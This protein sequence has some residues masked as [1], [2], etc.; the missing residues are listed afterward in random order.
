MVGLVFSYRPFLSVSVVPLEGVSSL[1][2]PDSS[3]PTPATYVRLRR[4]RRAPGAGALK[5]RPSDPA[6]GI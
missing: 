5:D 3:V 4:G 2:M 1:A 6:I